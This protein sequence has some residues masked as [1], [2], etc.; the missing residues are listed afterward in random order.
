M[1]M[2]PR[3]I[4]VAYAASSIRVFPL[5][6]VGVT[7][8]GYGVWNGCDGGLA[9]LLVPFLIVLLSIGT[10]VSG[11]SDKEVVVRVSPLGVER[12]NRPV[13]TNKSVGT[14]YRFIPRDL[15]LDCIVIERILS[16]N[17]ESVVLF[18]IRNSRGKHTKPEM[19]QDW[20]QRKVAE[21]PES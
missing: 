18:R 16:N 5:V 1:N 3:E 9:R 15:I 8:L 20:L 21:G 13:G 19:K 14:C 6:V 17:V 10:Y 7:L 2:Q 12:A 4:G 11:P